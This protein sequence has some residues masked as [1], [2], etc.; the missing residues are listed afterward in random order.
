MMNQMG[1]MTQIIEWY[2]DQESTD[3]NRTQNFEKSRT[4]KICEIKDRIYSKN[5]GPK[6]RTTLNRTRFDPFL[7]RTGDFLVVTYVRFLTFNPFS[8]KASS[9]PLV[10]KNGLFQQ[11]VD[12]N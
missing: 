2:V 11:K 3:Q 10:T 5:W 1:M 4:G 6:I 8:L 7:V 9:R 12:Q